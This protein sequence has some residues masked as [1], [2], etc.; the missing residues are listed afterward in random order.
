M[1]Y[2]LVASPHAWLFGWECYEEH[3]FKQSKQINIIMGSEGDCPCMR[4]LQDLAPSNSLPKVFS[5][6]HCLYYIRHTLNDSYCHGSYHPVYILCDLSYTIIQSQ[7]YIQTLVQQEYMIQFEMF[8]ELK[9]CVLCISEFKCSLISPAS[10]LQQLQPSQV[11]Y[12]PLQNEGQS[13]FVSLTSMPSLQG[14]APE[15]LSLLL[16]PAAATS[17]THL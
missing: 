5:H 12:A 11:F 2:G 7:L 10:F 13:T 14:R 4:G 9:I 8:P 15:L 3:H 6:C 17:E 1:N 16:V